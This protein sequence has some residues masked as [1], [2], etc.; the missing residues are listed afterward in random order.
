LFFIPAS[1]FLYFSLIPLTPLAYFSSTNLY[2]LFISFLTVSFK[3]TPFVFSLTPPIS[4]EA[5]AQS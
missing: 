2:F 1:L 3:F 5:K 4:H